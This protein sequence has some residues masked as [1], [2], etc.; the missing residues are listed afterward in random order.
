MQ[1]GYIVSWDS[2]VVHKP[3]AQ[4]A[5]EEAHRR[6]VEGKKVEVTACVKVFM[7]Q[8]QQVWTLPPEERARLDTH[9][10]MQVQEPPTLEPT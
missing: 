8:Y 9:I 6:M 7:G 10:R 5:K 2:G 3:N 4:E 1:S